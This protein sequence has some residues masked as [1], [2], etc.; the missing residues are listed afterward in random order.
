M[1]RIP[2]NLARKLTKVMVNVSASITGLVHVV[3]SNLRNGAIGDISAPTRAAAIAAM[4]VWA[5]VANGGGAGAIGS[6]GG[7]ITTAYGYIGEGTVDIPEL[8][9]AGATANQAVARANRIGFTAQIAA[10][11]RTGGTLADWQQYIDQATANVSIRRRAI[12]LGAARAAI[13]ASYSIERDDLLPNERTAATIWS[14]TGRDAANNVVPADAA[15]GIA[16]QAIRLTTNHTDARGDLTFAEAL[17]DRMD[18][19]TDEEMTFAFAIYRM[20]LAAPPLAGLSLYKSKHHFLSTNTRAVEAV[21]GQVLGDCDEAVRTWFRDNELEIRDV[22][23]HKAAHPITTGLLKTL[24]ASLETKARLDAIDLAAATVRLPYIEPELQAAKAYLVTVDTIASW[25]ATKGHNVSVP[26][27][28][29]A[30]AAAE[31]MPR[32]GNASPYP[33]EPPVSRA[34][35]IAGELSARRNRALNVVAWSLG[36][37][38]GMCDS[39]VI[40]YRDLSIS[41][42]Y[43]INRVRRDRAGDI[44]L[45]REAYENGKRYERNQAERGRFQPVT[46]TDI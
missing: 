7:W 11:P 12:V 41:K 46:M 34:D 32:T 18:A 39:G 20:A 23:W 26:G 9:A 15:G 27:L 17:G 10:G 4:W 21:E 42:A 45:G 43:S 24:A 14:A 1:A 29:A 16:V 33:G 37:I 19:L 6:I 38:T 2:V 8:D 35:F 5:E 31:A 30:V 28:E 44:A 13:S 36:V 40:V 22:L 3:D 25:A